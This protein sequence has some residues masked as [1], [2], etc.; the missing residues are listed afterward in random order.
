MALRVPTSATRCKE[1][2]HDFSEDSSRKLMFLGPLIAL[3]FLAALTVFSAACLLVIFYQ[4]VE[5][6]TLVD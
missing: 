4:P 2:F 1:C 6:H 5:S 3:G